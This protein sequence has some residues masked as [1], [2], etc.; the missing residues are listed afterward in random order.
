MGLR[1]RDDDVNKLYGTQKL[2]ESGTYHYNFAK[3]AF[4]SS[5]FNLPR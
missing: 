1:V 5:N 4:N 3:S 2:S